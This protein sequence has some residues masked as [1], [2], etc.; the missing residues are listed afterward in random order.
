MTARLYNHDAMRALARRGFSVKKI[1]ETHECAESTVR[2]ALDPEY[3]KRRG[4]YT[5]S[6]IKNG[7]PPVREPKDDGARLSDWRQ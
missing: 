4:A 5:R 6:Y 7:G 2:A 1:A 3:A